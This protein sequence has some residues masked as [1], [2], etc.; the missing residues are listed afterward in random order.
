MSN[1]P[2]VL[3]KSEVSRRVGLSVRHLERL[4]HENKFPRRIRLSE[5]S[6]GWLEHEVLGWLEARIAASRETAQTR[7]ASEAA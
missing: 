3:R 7:G 6:A 4:E 1:L 5:N 2:V